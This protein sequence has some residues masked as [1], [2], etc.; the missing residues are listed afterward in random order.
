S[1]FDNPLASRFD[2]N[3]AVLYFDDVKVPW[4]RVF[5][6]RD[7]A[8]CQKQFHA[9]PAHVFQNYQ[10][11]IRLMVKLRF[12]LGIA[13]KIA[14]ANGIDAFPQTRETLGQLAAE[15]AMVEAFVAAMEV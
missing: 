9:T 5:V 1:V 12:L 14:M 3:D 13:R 2:E 8:M 6:S 15:A 7:V 10:C 4:D 11:Q